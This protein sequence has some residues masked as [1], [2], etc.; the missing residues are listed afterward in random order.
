MSR[1]LNGQWICC[2]ICIRWPGRERRKAWQ[3]A[4]KKFNELN[5][6]VITNLFPRPRADWKAKDSP[7]SEFPAFDSPVLM[8]YL[9]WFTLTPDHNRTLGLLVKVIIN[10]LSLPPAAQSYF[11]WHL[12]HCALSLKSNATITGSRNGIDR[13]YNCM[14]VLII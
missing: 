8:V 3:G 4:Q 2:V 9:K 10:I 1:F 11:H 13:V 6:M 14:I 5:T 7:P 12:L